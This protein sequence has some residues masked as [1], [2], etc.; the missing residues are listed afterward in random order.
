MS[1]RIVII[2][3]GVIGS[4][5]AYYL[6]LRGVSVML[7]EKT[8]IAAAASGK[9]GG[10]LAYDW[11]DSGPLKDLSRKSYTLHAELATDMGV[12]YGYRKLD[13]LSMAT[14]DAGV[15]YKKS[16][17]IKTPFPEWV[18][19]TVL[20]CSSIG[21]S[22]TTAQVHPG[23]FS[24][25]LIKESEKRGLQVIIGNVETILL[26]DASGDITGVRVQGRED[27]PCGKVV[28]ALGPWTNK[29]REW[30]PADKANS[31][32]HIAAIKAHSIVL[33]PTAPIT[34]H[35]LFLAY[36]TEEGKHEEPE[37]YPRPDG[38]IYMCGA[39]EL[40][41]ALPDDASLV[42]PS[43]G[44]CES[45]YRMAQTLYGKVAGEV[46]K[47]Q[48]CF[49][50]ESHKGHP[51]I[52]KIESVGGLYIAT[53]HSC[54]GILNSPATGLAMTELLLDGKASSVNIDNFTPPK[55]N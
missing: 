7:I 8:A 52:G 33:R 51:Y 19:G 46:E 1:E 45:I 18:T 37:V 21:T 17:S 29:A 28:L 53:G 15:K 50:P 30:L 20:G 38:T 26:D 35:A 9:A 55:H 4:C 2:G 13:T 34:P 31:I 10:F 43:E 5:I 11:N 49:L 54:W 25:A 41:A 24:H 48:A 22:A 47:S 32:P 27:I 44:K 3:G 40:D 16:P 6:T 42:R 23:L 36:E 14:C 39:A 12:A